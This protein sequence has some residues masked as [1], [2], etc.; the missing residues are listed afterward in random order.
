MRL[1]DVDFVIAVGGEPRVG[2]RCASRL[3]VYAGLY[4]R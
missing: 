1:G 4:Y 2:V 3:A